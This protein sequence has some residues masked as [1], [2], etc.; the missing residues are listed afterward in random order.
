M[1]KAWIS[2]FV[3][4][5]MV[6]ASSVRGAELLA[7]EP[8]IPLPAVHGR[9]DHMDVDLSRKRLFV[10]E[11][12]NNT[13]DVVDLASKK[14]VRRISGLDEPQGVG[15]SARADVVALSN[16]GDGTVRL[17]RGNDLAPIG[18]VALGSDADDMRVDPESGD[19][20]VAYGDGGLAV[21]D[22]AK[23]QRIA[24]VKLP[25]HPESFQ[26]D[27]KT[28]QVYVNLPRARQIAVVDLKARR[29]IAKWTVPGLFD[30]F[31]MALEPSGKRLAIGFWHPPRLVL[32]DARTGVVEARLRSCADADDV[33]SDAIRHRIY[34]SCG[35]G[36]VSVF[37]DRAGR[38]R[39]LGDVTTAPGARTSLFVPEMDRLYVA[40]PARAFGASARILVFRPLGMK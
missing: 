35:A 37:G 3:I 33:Y 39:A 13:L 26:L 25:T 38:F 12:G 22:P 4:A 21:I 40:A 28:G 24:E 6:A 19:F 2:A 1:A 32:L 7:P 16:G 10:A 15:Y 17:Y 9:I 18:R 30:N 31:P 11:Y 27:P 23:K 36:V 8:S 34:V 29:R 14:R 20:I 5:L